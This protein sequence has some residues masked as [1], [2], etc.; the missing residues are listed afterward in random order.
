MNKQSDNKIFAFKV[1]SQSAPAKQSWQVR[2]K[3]S[4][5]GCSGR[6]TRADNIYTGARD[7]G[8]YC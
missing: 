8:I 4:T 6:F 1:A 5:A 7:A 2:S 3:V